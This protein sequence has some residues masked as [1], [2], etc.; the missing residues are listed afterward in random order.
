VFGQTMVAQ[1]TRPRRCFVLPLVI[2]GSLLA[3]LVWRLFF[4]DEERTSF[5]EAVEAREDRSAPKLSAPSRR[6]AL[7]GAARGRDA[8]PSAASETPTHTDD[9]IAHPHPITP[10]HERIFRENALIWALNGAMDGKDAAGMRKLLDQ[11]KA[12]YP[13]DP[14]QLR[15]GYDVIA[16]CIEQ[17][18]PASAAAGQCYYDRE[19]GSILRRF[20]GRHCLGNGD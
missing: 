17:P 11:Y 10:G 7:P 2:L 8:S 4:R 12:E 18:G 14:N 1:E 5:R 13:D 20:V 15:E 9:S 19:R 3:V 16:L 6:V